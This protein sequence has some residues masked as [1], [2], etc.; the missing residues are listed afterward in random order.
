MLS[1]MSKVSAYEYY[2]TLA[3]LTD[4]TGIHNPLVRHEPFQHSPANVSSGSISGFSS[5]D[6]GMASCSYAEVAW[7]WQ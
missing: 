1:F 5:Y 6:S 7:S 4:N 3:R 2:Y